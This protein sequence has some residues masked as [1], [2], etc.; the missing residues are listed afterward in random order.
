LISPKFLASDYCWDVEIKKALKRYDQKEAVV[1]P[2]IL[3]PC[4]WKELPFGKIQSLPKDG[5]P[6]T[7]W[8]NQDE[9]FLDVIKGFNTILENFQKKGKSSVIIRKNHKK[10]RKKYLVFDEDII[11][12]KLPRG[13]VVL[14]N[15]KG[16]KESSWAIVAEY[17]DYDGNWR[18]GT[19]YHIS[20]RRSWETTETRE[21]QC[22]KLR[23]PISDWIYTYPLFNLIMN[24]RER[25]QEGKIEKI[26]NKHKTEYGYFEYF[27]AK[28]KIPKP[29][30]PEKFKD[31]YKNGELRDIVEELQTYP[32]MNYPVNRLHEIFDNNRRK[33]YLWVY[34]HLREKHPAL[35]FVKEIV[36]EYNKNFTLEQ[37]RSWGRKL[38]SAL[39]NTLKFL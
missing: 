20:Y 11:L 6:I 17:Y 25:N 2:I 14:S 33:A 4:D 21:I 9:A 34:E 16:E 29:S 30:I 38:S 24:L 5:L 7:K 35:K 19:H 26:L 39:E 8:K 27:P 12:A 28:T 32:F 18:H 36:N 37:L 15:I 10:K 1:I 3:R 31:L 23:I 22:R 13:Y